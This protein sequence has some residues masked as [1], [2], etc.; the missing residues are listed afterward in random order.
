[1]GVLDETVVG[2]VDLGERHASKKRPG[3]VTSTGIVKEGKVDE[4]EDCHDGEHDH[5]LVLFFDQLKS[6]KRTFKMFDC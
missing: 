5:V 2:G 4:E 1:M 3:K 6:F